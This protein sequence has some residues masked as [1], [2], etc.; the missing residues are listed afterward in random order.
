MT[1]SEVI[2]TNEKGNDRLQVFVIALLAIQVVLSG[3][4]LFRL[5]RLETLLSTNTRDSVS[6]PTVK[7]VEGVSAGDAP[8]IGSKD[9]PV[10]IVAFSDFECPYCAKVNP[11]LKKLLEK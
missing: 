5:T 9:A 1:N 8:F 10:T 7:V 2:K 11:T 6:A 4:F 3:I